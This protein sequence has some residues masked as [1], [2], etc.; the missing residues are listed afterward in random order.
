MN[1]GAKKT[2]KVSELKELLD[3]LD[4]DAFV[5]LAKDAEGN[6]YSPLLSAWSGIYV[7]GEES[8]KAYLQKLTSE[9]I[10]QGFSEEDVYLD[11]DGIRAIFLHP[12]T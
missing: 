12:T 8:G 1:I 11:D 5:V 6:G 4:D 10:E 9:D 7:G 3:Q 2:M